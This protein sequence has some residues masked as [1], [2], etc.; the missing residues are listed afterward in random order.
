MTLYQ[1][2]PRLLLICS[3]STSAPQ[4]YIVFFKRNIGDVYV[5]YRIWCAVYILSVHISMVQVRLLIWGLQPAATSM[6]SAPPLFSFFLPVHIVTHAVQAVRSR[7]FLKRVA[8]PFTVNASWYFSI[9]ACNHS[10]NWEKQRPMNIQNQTSLFFLT[11]SKF[12]AWFEASV[13]A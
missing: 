6:I 7:L 13:M 2:F 10:Q 12:L 9:T 1:L 4:K 11:S 5:V 3:L 8:Y